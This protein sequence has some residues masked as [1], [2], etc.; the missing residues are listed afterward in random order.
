MQHRVELTDRL[1]R[2]LPAGLC[3]GCLCTDS[4]Y[5]RKC[6]SRSQTSVFFSHPVC[7]RASTSRTLHGRQAPHRFASVARQVW[8]SQARNSRK[9][10]HTS[11]AM[12]NAE[13]VCSSWRAGRTL[14][15]VLHSDTTGSAP[16]RVER[17]AGI[18]RLGDFP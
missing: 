5:V 4:P 12:Y 16:R 10:F 1:Q 17:I 18:Q 8:L 7:A 14:A 13:A 2:S 3:G 9:K 11:D 15:E 6:T